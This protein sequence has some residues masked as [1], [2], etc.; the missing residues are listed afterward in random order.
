[1]FEITKIGTFAWHQQSSQM[2]KILPTFKSIALTAVSALFLVFLLQKVGVWGEVSSAGQSVVMSTGALDIQPESSKDEPAKKDFDFNFAIKTTA[3]A[4]INFDQFKG[5]V[6]F[7]NLWATWCGPCKAEMPGIQHLYEKMD[8]SKVVF[9]MLSIDK[10]GGQA[11]INDY[12][13]KNKFTFPVFMPSGYLSEQLQVPSIPT[14]FVINREGKIEMKKVGT[15]NYDT[16]KFRQYL[17][18]LAQQ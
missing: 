12:V 15:A 13:R 11:K 18:D 10:E 7:L 16:E 14:T 2:Q 5:K 9:V 3:G 17:T 1:L 4:R 8:T 6:V